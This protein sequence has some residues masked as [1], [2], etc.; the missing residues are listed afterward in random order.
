M[1][2]FALCVLVH[3]TTIKVCTKKGMWSEDHE[4]FSWGIIL[5]RI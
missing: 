4:V 5:K 2:Y 3:K 1:P